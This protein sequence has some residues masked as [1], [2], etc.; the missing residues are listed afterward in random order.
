MMY[1]MNWVSFQISLSLSTDLR[2]PFF[3][4]HRQFWTSFKLTTSYHSLYFLS[5]I[6][7]FQSLHLIRGVTLLSAN[8]G[9]K[10]QDPKKILLTFLPGTHWF[11]LVTNR[12][13]TCPIHRC[14][15]NGIHC[16]WKQAINHSK[17]DVTGAMF[18]YHFPCIIYSS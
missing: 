2:Q 18:L 10:I 14:Y 8:R 3:F 4:R 7:F 9:I 13:G 1:C 5:C 11:C 6:F 17:V 16:V 12:T 15:G